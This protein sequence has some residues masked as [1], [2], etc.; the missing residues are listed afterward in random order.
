MGTRTFNHIQY[1]SDLEDYIIDLENEIQQLRKHDVIGRSK[2]L[3]CP[4]CSQMKKEL[5]ELLQASKEYITYQSRGNGGKLNCAIENAEKVLEL[6]AVSGW[7]EI[8]G[9]ESVFNEYAKFNCW[10]RFDDG[11]ECR[12]EDEHPMAVMTHFKCK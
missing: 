7:L 12:Y 6:G 9:N 4:H 5:K 11:T 3:P 1:E 8:E 10:C 2:Q